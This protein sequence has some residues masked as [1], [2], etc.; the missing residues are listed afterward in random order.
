MRAEWQIVHNAANDASRDIVEGEALTASKRYTETMLT[1]ALR[2]VPLVWHTYT[3]PLGYPGDYLAMVRMYDGQRRGDSIF[4]R[5]MDQIGHEER[6]A[7][8][9][10]VRKRYLVSQLERCSVEARQRHAEPVRFVS[11]GSGPAR[12]VVDFLRTSPPG[13]ELE[14]VLID[15][16]EQALAFA[17]EELHEA[18]RPHG[19][20]VR[21]SCRHLSF[22]QVFGLPELLGEVNRA[23]MIYTAGLFDY[24]SDDVGRALMNGCFAL[25]RDGG[26]LVVGNAAAGPG[27]RWMPEFVHDW[28]MIYR[29]EGELRD[30]ARDFADRARIEIDSDDSDAW[31]F[32]VAHAEAGR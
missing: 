8:T 20:R 16:D 23:D 17:W 26:R 12:E 11:I 21:I 4:A 7:A 5:V 27:V 6:L 13:P 2:D 14:F 10:P 3:K 18:A 15:Q 25:L 29:T 9:V 22:A 24:L 19:E 32:L 31:L 30:L 1:S 28:T